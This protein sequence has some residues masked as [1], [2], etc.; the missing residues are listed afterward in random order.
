MFCEVVL[1]FCLCCYPKEE[2]TASCC[3]GGESG[4]SNMEVLENV[5]LVPI[6]RKYGDLREE[7]RAWLFCLVLSCSLFVC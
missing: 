3:K 7:G 6:I 5:V 4:F 1:L 2:P